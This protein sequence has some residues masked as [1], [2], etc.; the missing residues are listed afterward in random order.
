MVKMSSFHCRCLEKAD[1]ILSPIPCQSGTIPVDFSL[2][3]VR[4]SD[5]K[6]R[7]YYKTNKKETSSLKI[8]NKI[9]VILVF[10][11]LTFI[12]LLP[13]SLHPSCAVSE[14]I[15]SLLNAWILSHGHHH[16][17]THPLQIFHANI[18]YPHP[19][20]LTYSEHLFPQALV[21]APIQYLTNNP[22][23]AYNF[24]FY[25][26]YVLNGFSM[27][28]LVRY[29]TKNDLI[30]VIC[31]IMFTF[32]AF[33]MNHITHLQLLHSWPIPLA[34]LYLHKFF[35]DQKWRHSILFSVF[36]VIQAMCCIYY[37][38]FFLAIMTLTLPLFLLIH[39][40]RINLIG[41]CKLAI[42]LGLAGVFLFFFS[43]PYQSLFKV[44]RFQ[45][46]LTEGADLVNFLA[47]S[48]NNVFLSKFMTPLGRHEYFLSPGIIALV[49]AVVS[50]L[51]MK[52]YFRLMAKALRV[53]VLI[54]VSFCLF[55][56]TLTKV[57]G[58]FSLNLGLF[59]LSA[60]N[61]AK[62]IFPVLIIGLLILLIGLFR[63]LSQSEEKS[64]DGHG[65][66]FL[67]LSLLC[68]ALFLSFGS[69]L[70]F[71]G[72]STSILPLPFK[73]FY[74]HVPGFKGIRVPS[75]FAIFVIF[76][77]VLLAGF[78]LRSILAKFDK[79]KWVVWSSVVFL[80]VL[81]L[82]YLSVPQRTRVVPIKDDIPPAY[83][84]LEEKAKPGPIIELPF[85]KK[86]GHDAVYMYF[87]IFHRKNLVNGYSG[88]IPP[89]IIYIRKVFEAFPS[90]AGLDILKTLGIKYVV[91]H[92]RMFKN[93]KSNRVVQSLQD[94]FSS[95]LRLIKTL[96]YSPARPHFFENKFGE[97]LI[98]EV[99]PDEE[100]RKP[101]LET[102]LTAISPEAWTITSNRNPTHLPLLRDDDLSTMWSTRRAKKTGDFLLVELTEPERIEKI[103][104]F[105]GEAVFDY[106][107]RIRVETSLDGTRWRTFKHLYSPGEFTKNLISSPFTLVQNIRLRG[108]KIKFL[109][110]IQSGND[111][112]SWWSVAELR[113]YKKQEKNA[114]D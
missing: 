9:L 81:N 111:R 96:R 65:Y 93:T 10:L 64:T 40:K 80:L 36:L 104:L 75:R 62:Q 45:R 72:D 102:N 109:K 32:N 99:L 20:T 37:G 89:A 88:F 53:T 11:L 41:L 58:G 17:F 94:D 59:S 4:N 60:H 18:F 51:S 38:L 113:I 30:G 8:N 79:K 47:A 35:E 57:T 91:L 112:T 77:T 27:F 98:Y 84:W 70:S 2:T 33:N 34:F 71:L 100:H 110:I 54:I 68:W 19:L 23:L 61:A 87:S 107:I 114:E 16:F 74:E 5:K 95:E 56:I 82:E 48:P 43:L 63:F 24:V 1:Y 6:V 101:E 22:I 28:L 15:D 66:F 42:P 85:H 12:H 92:L 78:G 52:R 86:I 105:Q 73:W 69:S 83:R 39:R 55:V 21:S 49:L 67:Y 29:L 31:G 44:F 106:A 7:G 97:D 26:A 90:P 13:L 103:S 50:I 3:D 46:G 14:T 108:K 76:S 25:L